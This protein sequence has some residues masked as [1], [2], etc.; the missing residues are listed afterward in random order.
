MN[1]ALVD[2]IAN[3]LL[4]DGY[5]LYPYRPSTRNRQRWTFGGLYPASYCQADSD[6]TSMQQT[7]CL[8]VGTPET[9]VEVVVRFLHLT[10]R[11]VVAIDAPLDSWPGYV[12]PMSHAVESLRVGDGLYE[13]RQE[14]E[15]REAAP[16]VADLK[17]LWR[18]GGIS[19]PFAFAGGVRSEP[20]S[21]SAGAIVGALARDQE[22]ISGVVEVSATSLGD[23][24]SRLT[25]RTANTSP[26]DMPSASRDAAL[27]RSLISA[28]VI[29]GV[30]SGAFVSLMNPPARWRD[31]ASS[32]RNIGA[33]PVLVGEP[34]RADVMLSG[35]LI[36]YDF[37]Q[38]DPETD[39][40]P[41]D[42]IEI[43]ELPPRPTS[44]LTNGEVRTKTDKD[45]DV[46][47]VMAR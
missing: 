6:D 16:V 25:V 19:H 23:G 20:L 28:H 27:R 10:A 39:G 41:F 30:E 38:I 26:L 45:G 3:A 33:W 29:L 17:T 22:A 35:S 7:E 32:C 2:S 13:S 42:A 47:A 44:A 14:A 5:I 31:A 12:P 15:Q 43:D 1:R 18:A 36:L 46:G 11:Q 4:F 9:R 40:S 21:D 8:V 34:G 37:P 24:L